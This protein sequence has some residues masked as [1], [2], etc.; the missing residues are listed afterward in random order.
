[1][2]NE[3]AKPLMFTVSL[4]YRKVDRTDGVISLGSGSVSNF[5]STAKIFAKQPAGV[6]DGGEVVVIVDVCIICI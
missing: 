3:N 6:E 4:E 1:M 5:D 2:E